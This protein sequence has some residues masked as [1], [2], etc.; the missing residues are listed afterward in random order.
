M[1]LAEPGGTNH[2]DSLSGDLCVDRTVATYLTSGDLP[3]RDNDA[4]WDKTCAPLPPPVPNSSG[5][6]SVAAD[7]NLALLRTRFGLAP[8]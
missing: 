4:Q 8:T 1:L 6:S 7:L 3:A 2:A 5:S